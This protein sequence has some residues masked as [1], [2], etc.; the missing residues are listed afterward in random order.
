M[1][2]KTNKTK[3]N[4]S[5]VRLNVEQNGQKNVHNSYR[6]HVEQ[7]GQ[8]KVHIMFRL[9]VEQGGRKRHTPFFV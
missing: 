6:L 9:N 4:R 5:V 1:L 3:V 8:R 2:N 7:Y